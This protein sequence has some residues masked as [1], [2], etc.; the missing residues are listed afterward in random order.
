M[1][2]GRPSATTFLLAML[3]SA[4]VLLAGCGGGDSGG[5]SGGDGGGGGGS[6]NGGQDA[7][8]GGD[9]GGGGSG[10]RQVKIVLGE[11]DFVNAETRRLS[12]QPSADQQSED[13]VDLRVAKNSQVT[14]DGQEAE[15]GDIQKGQQVQ[16]EYV[17]G[18]GDRDKA[19]SVELF[20]SG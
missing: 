2:T 3:V 11:V 4:A 20:S 7:A 14:L 1:R 18:E 15:L 10:Q 13:P 6:E 12:V 16:V 5:G 19:R 9:Q 8:N 17:D